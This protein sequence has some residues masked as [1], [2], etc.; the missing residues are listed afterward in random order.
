MYC[1][2]ALNNR[3]TENGISRVTKMLILHTLICR[4]F[5]AEGLPVRAGDMS[6]FPLACLPP[7]HKEPVTYIRLTPE[8]LAQRTVGHL[9]RMC[10]VV[11][12]LLTLLCDGALCGAAGYP[13]VRHAVICMTVGMVRMGDEGPRR[14]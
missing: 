5:L 10:S 8:M 2:T 9:T 14:C 3:G 11:A 13:L 12:V 7:A 6:A 1:S 4:Y